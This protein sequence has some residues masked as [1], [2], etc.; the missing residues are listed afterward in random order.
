MGTDETYQFK[1]FVRGWNNS[2]Q[3][4]V[5]NEREASAWLLAELKLCAGRVGSIHSGAVPRV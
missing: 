1:R 2:P 3:R 5:K 4:V